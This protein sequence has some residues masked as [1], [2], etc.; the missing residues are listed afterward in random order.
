MESAG[1]FSE[2]NS[3]M[4]K[5]KFSPQRRHSQHIMVD[6]AV[7]STMISESNLSEKDTVLEIGAGTGFLTRLIAEKAKVLA[8]EQDI[9][10]CGLLEKEIPSKNLRVLCGDIRKVELPKYNKVVSNPPYHISS[11]II[12]LLT[13]RDF[14]LA[15][16]TFEREFVFKLLAEEGYREYNAL[17]VITNYCSKPE[18]I[19]DKISSSSFFPRPNAV[20][21]LVKLAAAKRFGKAKNEK[22]FRQF[23][24]SVFRYRNKNIGNAMEKAYEEL[25][26]EFGIKGKGKYLNASEKFSGVKVCQLSVKEFVEISNL[27]L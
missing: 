15:L 1:L 22:F 12:W 23:V 11:D 21:T 16:L 9:E 18:V 17:S 13:G 2:L 25:S 5:Y 14:G 6:E 3:L 27:A 20:S 7:L 24:K 19:L 10:F 4:A 26:R 8:V